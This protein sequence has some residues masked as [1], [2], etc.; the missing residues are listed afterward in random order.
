[1]L[2]GLKSSKTKSV[3]ADYVPKMTTHKKK[4]GYERLLGALYRICSGL[5]DD[6]LL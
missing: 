6:M 4:V 2:E 1:M 3:S 5:E